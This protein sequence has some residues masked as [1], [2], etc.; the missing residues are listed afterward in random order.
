M[1]GL[2]RAGA[3]SPALVAPFEVVAGC[4]VEE[5]VIDYTP[6]T[7]T[8]RQAYAQRYVEQVEYTT[9]GYSEFDRWFA[10]EIEKAERRGREAVWG[11]YD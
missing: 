8:V 9:V 11:I 1:H 10:S 2:L 7:D 4:G 6:T 5:V 3:P